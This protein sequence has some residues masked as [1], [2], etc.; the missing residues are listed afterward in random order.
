MQGLGIWTKLAPFYLLLS[1]L[2]DV[3]VSTDRE[4]PDDVLNVG[5]DAEVINP[6]HH[7]IEANC[8]IKGWTNIRNRFLTVF[9]ESEHLPDGQVCIICS[10]CAE[11]HCLGCGPHTI[12]GNVSAVNTAGSIFFMLQRKGGKDIGYVKLCNN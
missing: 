6:N 1:P 4:L 9:T 5:G 12:V 2:G 8:S 7:E 3:A 11:A 10:S